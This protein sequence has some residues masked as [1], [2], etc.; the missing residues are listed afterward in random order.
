MEFADHAQVFFS[1]MTTKLQDMEK[2]KPEEF[3]Y[4]SMC[5]W[6]MINSKHLNFLSLVTK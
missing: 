2:K 1:S 4:I 5:T 3:S 6:E